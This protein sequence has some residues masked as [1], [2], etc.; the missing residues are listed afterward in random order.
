MPC[1]EI[2]VMHTDSTRKIWRS[3]C[4]ESVDVATMKNSITTGVNSD[5]TFRPPVNQP[6][7]TTD[8]AII[9][10]STGMIQNCGA[11]S[12]L[13]CLSSQK[14]KADISRIGRTGQPM[15]AGT[16]SCGRM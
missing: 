4:I 2:T 1:H 15:N 11:S 5:S 10:V 3:R 9:T 13:A 12:L 14:K 16:N 8:S 6:V 7:K